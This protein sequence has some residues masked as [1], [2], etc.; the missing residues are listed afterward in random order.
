MA[1][2]F[3]FFNK[4]VFTFEPSVILSYIKKIKKRKKLVFKMWY[5]IIIYSFQQKVTK[6]QIKFKQQQQQTNYTLD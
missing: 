2:N 3:F 1:D 4:K 6:L 5:K